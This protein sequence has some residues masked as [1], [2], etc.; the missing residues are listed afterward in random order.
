MSRE[1]QEENSFLQVLLKLI[2]SEV[3]AVFVF[4]QDVMPRQFWPHLVM[5]LVLVALTPMYLRLAAGVKSRTRLI[6][7][8]LSLVVWI[9]AMG[10]GPLRFVKAPFYEPWHGAV[11]L[12]VWTLVP[13]MLLTR[14]PEPK[15]A[16]PPRPPRKKRDEALRNKTVP[17]RKSNRR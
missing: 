7:S 1:I 10:T 3:I 2:P 6:L 15:P 11:L 14:A 8:T 5:A 17:K 9:Y 4:V 16:T 12:A 13:P